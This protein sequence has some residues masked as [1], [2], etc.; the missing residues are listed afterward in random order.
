MVCG[1][2][3]KVIQG[4]LCIEQRVHKTRTKKDIPSLTQ[5]SALSAYFHGEG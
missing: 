3:D 4:P 2:D 5:L 1:D